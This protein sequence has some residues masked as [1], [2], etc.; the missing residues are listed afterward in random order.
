MISSLKVQNE[1]LRRDNSSLVSIMS[2]NDHPIVSIVS[3]SSRLPPAAF[4]DKKNLVLNINSDI[5]DEDSWIPTK[6]INLANEF[7]LK[8]G[9]DLSPE[10]I[11]ELLRS[12]NA[13]WRAREKK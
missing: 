11:T 5:V 13:I 6:A 2:K 1:Q 12:L 8:H 9:N 7:R 3:E 10:L 4:N